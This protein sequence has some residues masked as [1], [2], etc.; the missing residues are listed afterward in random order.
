MKKKIGDLT[1]RELKKMVSDCNNMPANI[2][3]VSYC[4]QC[5]RHA[6][7]DEYDLD[8]EIEVQE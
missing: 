5:I 8:E 6:Q 2:C 1:L 4:S 3:S 7:I